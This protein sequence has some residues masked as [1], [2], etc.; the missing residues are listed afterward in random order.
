MKA[1]LTATLILLV[2]CQASRAGPIGAKKFQDGCVYKG[3]AYED[4]EF[5]PVPKKKCEDC[6]CFKGQYVMCYLDPTCKE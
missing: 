4:R 1:M 5:V 3:K 2:V 6:S